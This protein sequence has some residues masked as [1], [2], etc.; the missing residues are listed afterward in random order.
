MYIV[1]TNKT[2][3]TRAITY[4]KAHLY[5]KHAPKALTIGIYYCYENGTCI[6][7][8]NYMCSQLFNKIL[9]I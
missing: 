6:Y 4:R 5:M 7:I 1:Q 2:T 8:Y 3:F 9:S